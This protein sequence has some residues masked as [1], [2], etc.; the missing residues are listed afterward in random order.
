MPS[1]KEITEVA[2]IFLEG[3]LGSAAQLGVEEHLATCAGCRTW[4]RQ[5]EIT[6]RAVGAL[7]APQLSDELRARLLDQFDALQARRAAR[8]GAAVQAA[9]PPA[10]PAA[11][12]V[13][14]AVA[15]QVGAAR[16]P[17]HAVGDWAAS[18]ALAAVAFALALL[19]RRVTLRVAL[20]AA[21][22]ALA[23]AV[24][25]GGS[26]PLAAWR[27]LECL[28]VEL[29]TAAVVVGAAWLV[30]RRP[31]GHAV[32]GSWAVAGALAG[33]AA[34]Q[35]SCSEHLSLAHGVTSHVAGVVVVAA[36]ASIAARRS[37]LAERFE[38]PGAA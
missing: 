26:G 7:P 24:V 18:L 22:A 30:N 23:A 37:R 19:V 32:L 6:A 35:V 17:S 36:A 1:C 27:G 21:S 31:M 20:V 5:L 34:L 13:V 3:G 29:A 9:G 14:G 28:L 2:T 4:M 12:A 25:R 10:W 8:A 11:V 15:V 38:P 33:A 16:S